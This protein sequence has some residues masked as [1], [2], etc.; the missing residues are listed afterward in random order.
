ML[1][2]ASLKVGLTFLVLREHQNY[3]S[4]IDISFSIQLIVK[5]Q[6]V[7]FGKFP[8]CL[9]SEDVNSQIT[10]CTLKRIQWLGQLQVADQYSDSFIDKG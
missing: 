3:Y 1:F 4:L 9:S 5:P 8:T 6:T 7:N 10:Y 2:I